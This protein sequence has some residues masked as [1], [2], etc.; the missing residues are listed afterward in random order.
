MSAYANESFIS[1]NGK[2]LLLALVLHVALGVLLTVTINSTRHAVTPGQLAIK[3]VVIDNT[4]KRLKKE[5]EQAEA[6]RLAREQAEA[7]RKAREKLEEEQRQQQAK[8]DEEQRQQALAEQKRKAEADRQA[9]AKKKVDEDK[10]RVAEI[11]AKQ[12]EKQNK[13][14]D[15]REQ[16]QREAE[17][18]RQLA[19]EEGRMQ[20]QNSGKL[21]LYQ[22]M[23]EQHIAR[24][25]VMPDS[26]RPGIVCVVSIRQS[27]GGVV[28]SRTV[29]KWNG[30]EA[31]RQSLEAAVLRSSPLP[32]PD[33]MRLFEPEIIL[34]VR[35]EQ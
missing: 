8:R 15:A 34:T 33:D 30:D 23:L 17:L 12:L 11:K 25:W 27:A 10:K 3:A 16:V 2:Y 21:S 22:A 7:E 35:P 5:K 31:V 6:E 1:E 9:V 32:L 28:L 24:N 19:E 14:R 26:A 18:K 20:A 4:A 13:E 29:G